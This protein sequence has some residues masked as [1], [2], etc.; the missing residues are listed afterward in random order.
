MRTS[1]KTLYGWRCQLCTINSPRL[2][3]KA[4][5]VG[6]VGMYMRERT[7]KWRKPMR[8]NSLGDTSTAR[9]RCKPVLVWQEPLILLTTVEQVAVAV[10]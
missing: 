8:S 6:L 4:I 2:V 7:T 5:V 9:T 1:A 3:A 10:R